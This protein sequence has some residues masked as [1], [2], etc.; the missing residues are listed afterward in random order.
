MAVD[1]N[2]LPS[3]SHAVQ[4]GVQY[5]KGATSAHPCTAMDHHGPTVTRVVGPHVSH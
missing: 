2:C 3:S 5:N 4:H 1:I